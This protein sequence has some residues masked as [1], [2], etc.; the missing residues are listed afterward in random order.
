MRHFRS[1]VAWALVLTGL[2]AAT[3]QAS[4]QTVVWNPGST[5]SSTGS[6]LLGS[7]VI[8]YTTSPIPPNSGMTMSDAGFTTGLGTAPTVSAYGGLT[9]VSAGVLGAAFPG[10]DLQTITAAQ[11]LINPVL[12]FNFVDPGDVFDFG[13][14]TFALLSANQVSQVGSQIVGD[15]TA[16]NSTNDGFAIQ[17]L[18]NFTSIQFFLV[19]GS[20]PGVIPPGQTVAFTVGQVGQAVPEPT[21]VASALLGLGLV[22]YTRYRRA[23]AGQ[24]A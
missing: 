20:N 2:S 11:A 8:T 16:Q 6:G 13:D 12:L 4:L 14:L 19:G 23:R 1:L 7:N 18:G 22:G 9:S 15:I 21:T 10:G 24:T 17:L 3:A 5:L